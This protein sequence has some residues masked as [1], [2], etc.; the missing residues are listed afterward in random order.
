MNSKQQNERC[1]Q[2]GAGAKQYSLSASGICAALILAGAACFG[3][4]ADA[5]A[6]ETP[7][8]Q[9]GDRWCVLGDSIT[10]GGRYHELIELFYLTRYPT[11]TVDVINCGIAGDSATGAL[12][13]LNWD[14]LQAKPTTVSVM[15]GMND[16]GGDFPK[17]GALNPDQEQKR[18]QR[19]AAYE[20]AMRSLTSALMA[21]GAKVVLIRPSIY[22]DT[23]VLPRENNCGR[24]AA[25]AGYGQIVQRIA[26]DLKLPA[27][28]FNSP[29]AAI[30]AEQQKR[31]PKF[32]IVGPDRVHP[33]AP[34]H[35]VMAFEFLKAQRV[36]GAVSRIAIDAAAGRATASENCEVSDLRKDV[37]EISFTALERALPFP[38]GEQAAPAL[39]FVPFERELNQEILAVRGLAD[40]VYELSIDAKPV[41]VATNAEFADG[42]NLAKEQSTP[43]YQQAVAVETALRKKWAAAG[44]QRTI[45]YIEHTALSDLPRPLDPTQV[46]AKLA[47][48]LASARGKS[49]EGYVAGQQKEYLKLKPMESELPRQMQ[50]ALAAA[51]VAA[52]PKAHRFKLHRIGAAESREQRD[53][54]MAWW[55]EARFGLFVH[56][57]LYSGLAGTWDGK[58]A[59]TSGGMEWIENIVKADTDTYAKAAIPLFKPKPGFAAQW[60]RLAK[61]A[62][63]RYLVFTTKHHEGFALH[64]SKLSDFDA[65]SVLGRDLVKEIVGAC[66]AE[67][68]RI[69][70]Y[71]SVIDWHHSQYEYARSKQLPHPLSG[72]PYPN[73]RRDH[74]KYLDYLFGEVNELVSNYGP[75]DVLWWDY[76]ALD[77]QGQEAWRA[78]DLMKLVRGKQPGIVMN[79]RLFRS[80]EA[81]WTSM[82]VEGYGSHMDWVYGD[83]ITP[84]QHIPATGMPGVDWESCMTLNTTWGYSEHDHAW[85]SD[86]T[87]IRNLIDIA[88]KG[89]NYL[90]NIG[91]K[92]DGSVPE[93]SVKSLLAMGAWM[94]VNGEAIYGT[95]ASPFDKL[96]WGRCTQKRL[97]GGNTRLYFHV[98][99]W[100]QHGELVLPALP[101]KA[102]KVTLLANGA[103]LPL[104]KTASQTV[105]SLPA[106]PVD[107]I[108]SVIALELAK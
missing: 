47:A 57:G 78:F 16:V 41:H 88:S 93:E 19:A 30:D 83:F 107:K 37:D 34:G 73:G 81:G 96:T 98:F 48:Q 25:L 60:A 38:V 66:R 39:S 36:P 94:K 52:Q 35:F 45:A 58:P 32:T 14:C 76:S 82:G 15:L 67:G 79:N 42:V 50:E 64:D 31:D 84:E 106:E 3:F 17:N 85:K 10:H 55:R 87:L 2:H 92:G 59:G 27:I 95:S 63:C 56:W 104:T 53:S 6:V 13:R 103:D 49:W 7:Q 97:P 4:V 28:D 71:H 40:G 51:R 29:M 89:G 102:L 91:P 12:K 74:S 26:D 80:V 77:F 75:V 101:G 105:I 108:A 54:R 72:K 100:P 43:Q 18:A 33:G 70:F 20:K 99:D 24:G 69:G 86:E 68:L 21:S 8:F 44:K 61:E 9:S 65:G 23:A 62:G 1:Q 22:D 5:A 90:L 46:P 11:R